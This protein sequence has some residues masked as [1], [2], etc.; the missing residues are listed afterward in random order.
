MAEAKK[1]EE[2]KEKKFPFPRATLVNLIRKNIK[3]GKQIKGIVKDEMNLWLGRLVEKIAKKM[4]SYPYT[5]ID[6]NMFKEA[7][8]IYE[9]L[10]E[11]EVERERIIKYLE[12]IK[13]DCDSLEKEID[14]K[15][16]K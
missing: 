6:Y 1:T 8:S 10:E 16:K 9:Q 3:P 12:K 14:R 2:I 7:I 11:I 15:F 4:D 13:S 5:Y